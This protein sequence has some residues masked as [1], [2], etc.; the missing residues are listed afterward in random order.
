[1]KSWE[2]D[3]GTDY[4]HSKSK[5]EF[6]TVHNMKWHGKVEVLDHIF[7][8]LVIDVGAWSASCTTGFNQWE[9]AFDAHWTWRVSLSLHFGRE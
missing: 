3:V 2:K 1:M 4:I 9:R 5:G 7:L 6:V 8:T